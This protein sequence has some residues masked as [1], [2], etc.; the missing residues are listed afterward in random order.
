MKSFADDPCIVRRKKRSCQWI[1]THLRLVSNILDASAELNSGSMSL[2]Y[3]R[4]QLGFDNAAHA[5]PD[6]V[7]LVMEDCSFVH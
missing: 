2:N 3:E 1:P 4:S 5:M 6:S 7:G